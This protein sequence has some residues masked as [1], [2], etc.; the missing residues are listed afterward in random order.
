MQ[1]PSIFHTALQINDRTRLLGVCLMQLS[2]V[3]QVSTG[4]RAVRLT[5]APSSPGCRLP[6]LTQGSVGGVS[7]CVCASRVTC[8]GLDVPQIKGGVIPAPGGMEG[9]PE[10]LEVSAIDLTD[11]PV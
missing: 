10:S 1:R 3:M 7:E 2:K 5:P 6:S 4:H 9:L 8:K 11:S